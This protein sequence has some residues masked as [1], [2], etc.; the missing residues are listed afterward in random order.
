MSKDELARLNKLLARVDRLTRRRGAK[1]ELAHSLGV[2]RQQLNGWLS[3]SKQPG[4]EIALQLLEWV[5]AVE[6]KTKKD[7]GVA[8]T[9]PGHKTRKRNVYEKP[10]SSR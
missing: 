7:P 8:V 3:G 5:A 9:T 10:K 1:S 6:V 4:A 2:S